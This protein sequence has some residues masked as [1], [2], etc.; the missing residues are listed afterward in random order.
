MIFKIRITIVSVIVFVLLLSP[1]VSTAHAWKKGDKFDSVA[2]SIDIFKWLKK[3][4]RYDKVKTNWYLVHYNDNLLPFNGKPGLVV[5]WDSSTSRPLAV[6]YKSSE[7]EY[8]L[9][10]NSPTEYYQIDGN[11]VKFVSVLSVGTL[12]YLNQNIKGFSL[13]KANW[14]CIDDKPCVDVADVDPSIRLPVVDPTVIKV[15]ERCRWHD[16]VCWIGNGITA[17]GNSISEFFGGFVKVMQNLMEFFSHLFIPGD[18]NLFVKAFDNIND[19]MHKKLGF[20]TYPF[21]FVASIFK[22]LFNEF[23]LGAEISCRP[24]LYMN[25]ACDPIC[26]PNVFGSASLCF[27][28]VSLENT[29]PSLWSSIIFIVRFCAALAL[30]ELMRV[31]YYSIVRS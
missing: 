20:L 31:K 12:V 13:G 2:L 5:S 28:I 29:F 9:D 17:I 8:Y 22:T 24:Q 16:I 7:F 15:T 30:V 21:D 14:Y 26:A 10:V 18:D 25:S 3:Q 4:P 11:D 27:D 19:Y 23:R 1:L 6:K